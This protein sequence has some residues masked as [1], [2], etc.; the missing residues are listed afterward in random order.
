MPVT[1]E[2]PQVDLVKSRLAH[3][4]VHILALRIANDIDPEVI[5][6]GVKGS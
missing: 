2:D 6:V 3:H 1:L 4:I 5:V